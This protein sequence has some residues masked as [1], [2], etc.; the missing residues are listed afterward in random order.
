MAETGAKQHSLRSS[1]ILVRVGDSEWEIRG[2]A[3]QLNSSIAAG[4]HAP[5]SK[6]A[7]KSISLQSIQNSSKLFQAAKRQSRPAANQGKWP[8]VYD[9][10]QMA[11]SYL[12]RTL[13]PK[14]THRGFSGLKG[15]LVIGMLFG[16]LAMFLFHQM[17]PHGQSVSENISLTSNSADSALPVLSSPKKALTV[18][19]YRVYFV[20]FGSFTNQSKAIN[21]QTSLQKQ[22]VHTTVVPLDGYSVISAAAVNANDAK[23]LA[24]TEQKVDASVTVKT[25]QQKVRPIP[26]LGVAD[27]SAIQATEQ[28]LSETTSGLL[29]LTAWLSDHGRIADTQT[30]MANAIADYP[31]DATIA[32]TGIA[33]EVQPILQSLKSADA[34]FKKQEKA[35]AMQYVLTAFVQIGALEGI[36]RTSV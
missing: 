18:P 32:E 31:G 19:G 3:E 23:A 11:V 17:A 24:K 9:V 5:V 8:L 26:V 7:D 13:F 6:S 27:A 10:I 21:K 25:I 15:G 12:I 30:A 34:S 4:V 35:K 28:W 16:C 33:D 2:E 14:Q 22:G 36:T 20:D 1:S 29:S